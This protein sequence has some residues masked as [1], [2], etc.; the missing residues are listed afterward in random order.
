MNNGTPITSSTP[1]MI[2]TAAP[3]DQVNTST[4]PLINYADSLSEHLTDYMRGGS[5]HWRSLLMAKQRLDKK[6][7]FSGCLVLPSKDQRKQQ[8]VEVR[9]NSNDPKQLIELLQELC[10]GH[11][12]N[13]ASTFYQMVNDFVSEPSL[14]SLIEKHSF[15]EPLINRNIISIDQSDQNRIKK[16][17][18]KQLKGSA[19]DT[20]S[21]MFSVFKQ[22]KQD[23][24]Q[25]VETITL[26]QAA[27]A[28]VNLY[29]SDKSLSGT[30]LTTK[31]NIDGC[32]Q[33]SEKENAKQLKS[34]YKEIEQVE[35][36]ILAALHNIQGMKPLY[37]LASQTTNDQDSIALKQ[38]DN[39][40][41]SI[42]AS[43]SQVKDK[44]LS[45]KESKEYLETKK[46]QLN[47]MIAFLELKTYELANHNDSLLRV[48]IL[49]ALK[50]GE[51][52]ALCRSDDQVYLN[53]PTFED[54]VNYVF[55]SKN[56]GFD[57][58]FSIRLK[59][60]LIPQS[61]NNKKCWSD[62]SASLLTVK[63][64][65]AGASFNSENVEVDMAIEKLL[66]EF[67]V[68]IKTMDRYADIKL[69]TF[70][71]NKLK[72]ET[73]DYQTANKWMK[74]LKSENEQYKEWL[75]IPYQTIAHT[76]MTLP[77]LLEIHSQPRTGIKKLQYLFSNLKPKG[78]WQRALRLMQPTA[79]LKQADLQTYTNKI[80][81]AQDALS[82]YSDDPVN[83]Y[84]K[85][86]IL[87]EMM[88]NLEKKIP[89]YHEF[90][91]I[92]LAKTA[93]YEVISDLLKPYQVFKA[94]L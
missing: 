44:K 41:Q 63:F 18:I 26:R 71:P 10:K 47:N 56:K 34:V 59:R 35:N 70:L 20:Q 9:L 11:S 4:E 45:L 28:Q 12:K 2:S 23:T 93:Q 82:R 7:I 30:N 81:L 58:N 42:Q 74:H 85:K 84:I 77:A 60:T 38:V 80:A 62:I 76:A 48:P 16:S 27:S 3:L 55:S 14:A 66:T 65:I 53:Y 8:S 32:Q 50:N 57:N 64:S 72:I 21:R 94:G 78:I 92:K 43:L 5:K 51:A 19:K 25:W 54:K 17:I 52:E 22:A 88:F 61:I 49:R 91:G 89:K 13:T 36:K 75:K 6:P 90:F 24:Q 87:V 31:K 15:F 69:N 29:D 83:F 67:S 33:L 1:G 46:K 73:A 79:Y 40:F 86:A 39:W 68:N 37:Q